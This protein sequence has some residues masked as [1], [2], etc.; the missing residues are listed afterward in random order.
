MPATP[1]QLDLVRRIRLGDEAAWREC[2]DQF[3][4]RLL[5]FARSRLRDQ[6]L[7]EDVVQDAFIGFLN[8]LPNYDQQTPLD[9]FLFAIT[10]HKLTDQLRKQGRRPALNSLSADSANGFA[11]EPAGRQ[12]RASSLARSKEQ[13]AA[14]ELFLA[15]AVGELIQLWRQSG[16]YERLQCAELLFVRC[17]P[18]K[19][20]AMALGISE[21][22]V[23]N[24][25][26]FVVSK[27]KEAAAKS[28]LQHWDPIRLGLE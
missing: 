24:H 9:A 27:L 15:G 6:T 1:A 7:A 2:I 12:R 20:A 18:N 21:Q 28:H 3:E 22:A 13:S 5:A 26:Y 19:E 14:E 11:A 25:K 4:G 10:A 17:V 16:E 23:A 8:A